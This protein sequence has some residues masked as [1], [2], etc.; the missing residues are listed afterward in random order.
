[1]YRNNN[2]SPNNIKPNPIVSNLF[3]IS[4]NKNQ[5]D[6]AAAIGVKKVS[7]DTSVAFRYFNA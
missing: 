5:A 6:I 2:K 3:G 1:L 7:I 4:F